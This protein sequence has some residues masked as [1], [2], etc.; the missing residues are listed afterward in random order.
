MLLAFLREPGPGLRHLLQHLAVVVLIHLAQKPHAFRSVLSIVGRFLHRAASPNRGGLHK[1]LAPVAQQP[2]RRSPGT[3][4]PAYDRSA[5]GARCLT[6]FQITGFAMRRRNTSPSPL[7]KETGMPDV[8]F[9]LN[10]DRCGSDG[11]EVP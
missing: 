5:A 1:G 6:I 11:Y 2:I 3:D 8:R 10:A 9:L 7:G 4:N